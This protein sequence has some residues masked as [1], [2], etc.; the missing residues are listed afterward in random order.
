MDAAIPNMSSNELLSSVADQWDQFFPLSTLSLDALEFEFKWAL[1]LIQPA[2][3]F[4]FIS[5]DDH[6]FSIATLIFDSLLLDCG[7]S[8]LGHHKFWSPFSWD[9]AK[10]FWP[11]KGYSSTD[12]LFP[13]LV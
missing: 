9:A 11:V 3:S 10:F 1:F 12:Q 5:I 7:A 8:F 2:L 13:H 6:D 4:H